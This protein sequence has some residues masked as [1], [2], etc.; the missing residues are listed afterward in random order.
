M[1][2]SIT[3]RW[4]PPPSESRNGQITGYKI[5]YRKMKK[6]LQV[7]T[8]PANIRHF[9]IINLE[10]MSHYQV[11][12]AA[13]NINGTGPFSEWKFEQTLENDLDETK[14]PGVPRFLRTRPSAESIAVTW[15]SPAEQQIKVRGYVLGWGKGVPDEFVR[16]MDENARYFDITGLEPNNE[17]VIS[18]SSRN[19]V[20][21]SPP[22]YD[23][24]RTRDDIPVETMTPLEVPVGLRAITMSATAIVVY[25]TDTMLNKNQHVTDNRQYVVRYN[26]LGAVRYKYHNTSDLNVMI[27]DLKPNT[28]YEF[29]VK[30][31]KGKRESAWSMSVLNSTVQSLPQSPPR[32]VKA[33]VDDTTTNSIYLTWSSPKHS[34]GLITGYSVFYTTNKSR[35]D[36]DWSVQQVLGD[37][38]NYT[39][40]NLLPQTTYYFKIQPRMGKVVGPFSSIVSY[41]TGKEP[42][43]TEGDFTST[44]LNE[45]MFYII[46]VCFLVT[47][48]VIVIIVLVLLCRRKPEGTPEHAKKSYQKNNAGVKPPDLWIHHDQMEL[49]NM[50]K[51]NMSNDGASSSGAMT[52]P[53]SVG[54]EYDTEP[55]LS[56]ITNSLDKRTY[57]PGYITTPINS[58]TTSYPRNQYSLNRAHVSLEPTLS[59][60]NLNQSQTPSLAQTPENPYGY[61]SMP[62]NYR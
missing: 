32:D 58:G 24:V 33:R 43:T 9:E 27:N 30:V 14:V 35:E 23:Y 13:I 42:V 7:T 29:A 11:R 5:R 56:H 20:G 38:H 45:K 19:M 62:S 59:Q 6:A 41:K 46:A 44:F 8:T 52:L 4:E 50:E 26:P 17:Y 18:L 47:I 10:K 16:E 22:V 57:V 61:D 2:Q 28:Q 40:K 36:R 48:V 21:D 12:I 39:I 53:R 15:T 60:Q 25:W 1:L 3:I 51:S 54:H 37:S 55:S 34:S 49:K 31:V